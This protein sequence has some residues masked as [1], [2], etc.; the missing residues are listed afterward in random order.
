[1]TNEELTRIREEKKLGKKE[2]AALLGITPLRLKWYENGS[3]DIPDSIE[4]ML[5]EK[6]AKTA[7]PA[8]GAVKEKA[9]AEKTEVK[10]T[11]GKAGRKSKK[12]V[13]DAATDIKK[14]AEDKAAAE[15]IEVKKKVRKKA[16]KAEEAA[17]AAAEKAGKAKSRASL[18]IIIE[19]PMGGAI[20]TDEIAKKVPKDTSAVYVRVDRNKLYYV[21]KD[22]TAGDVY[23]W[24]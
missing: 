21:L 14:A 4:E 18:Q 20:S 3:I 12:A 1:M 9:A 16:R 7:A 17:D 6:A 2:F 5:R 15:E 24:E 23:I 8:E 22:S 19:S 13:K 11:A 10:K